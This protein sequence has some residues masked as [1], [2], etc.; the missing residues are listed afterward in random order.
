M[1]RSSR[2]NVFDSLTLLLVPLA[3][4]AGCPLGLHEAGGDDD[5][6]SGDGS[7]S[8]TQNRAPVADAGADFEVPPGTLVV[9]DGTAS[10]DADGD[11]LI[12]MWRQTTVAPLVELQDAFSSRPR[13]TAPSVESATAITFRLTVADGFS[14]AED[15]VVVTVVP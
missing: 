2:A 4:L 3:L 1:L 14:T 15:D 9:L 8:T 5:A 11:R 7:A 13:F 12:F 10:S 6:Q